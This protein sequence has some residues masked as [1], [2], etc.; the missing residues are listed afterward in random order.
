MAN[1]KNLSER[2]KSV[3][4]IQQVTKA[5]KMVAA[6]KVK[7]AQDKM[8]ISRPYARNTQELICRILPQISSTDISLVEK[9][10]VNNVGMIIVTSDRGFAGSFNSSVIRLAEK[11]IEKIGKDKVQLFCLGKKASEYFS[12][13][14]YNVK[15]TFFDFWKDMS[16]DTASDISKTFIGAFENQDIDEVHVIYNRFRTLASQD[17]IME[18]VLPVDFSLDYNIT[19]YNYD[20]EPGQKE[21]VST[22]IPKH[23]NV[24]M[25]Q[26]LL[27]SYSSEEAARMIAMDNATEN[28]KEII[29]ELKLEFNKARQAAITTEMLEIV[30]GAEALVD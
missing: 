30:G 7:K 16:Y 1:L 15:E 25:W 10:N 9:R 21:I 11:E 26:Q 29:K 2:I 24:Q 17:L 28:A 18:K 3:T 19:N 14:D 8:E 12:K 4:S 13:R 5:M 27:E 23:I 22:L 6:A 20:Y